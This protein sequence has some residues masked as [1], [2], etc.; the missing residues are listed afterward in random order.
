MPLTPA[1]RLLQELGITKPQEIDLE[2]IAYHA[3]ARIRFRP[4]QGCEARI[5]GSDDKAV[6]TVNSGS[7]HRRNRFSIAHELGHWHHHRGQ[8]LVCRAEE[9]RPRSASSPERVADGYAVDLIMPLYLFRPLAR[10]Q[11]KLTLKSIAAL[12]DVFQTSQTA[13]AIRIVESDI[14]PRLS[15]ATVPR[16]GSG[17][18][19]RRAFPKGGFRAI[20]STLTALPSESCSVA[21]PM[22]PCRAGS[23]QTL[24]SIVGKLT[25]SRYMSS[26]CVVDPRKC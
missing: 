19:A 15:S 2:A 17:S 18:H 26:Q 11:G 16:A 5:I 13:T 3:G 4:L 21:N 24:G 12:A 6:I 7:L 10:Q 20:R 25:A 22:I 23:A 8:C 1:E 9:Y 14:P